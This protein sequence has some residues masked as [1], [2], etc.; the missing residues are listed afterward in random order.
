MSAEQQPIVE[1]KWWTVDAPYDILRRRE[2]V[3]Q[4]DTARLADV[5]TYISY[6]NEDMES[7]YVVKT[8]IYQRDGYVLPEDVQGSGT[9]VYLQHEDGSFEQIGVT[10]EG[11][12]FYGQRIELLDDEPILVQYRELDGELTRLGV[13]LSESARIISDEK[14]RDSSYVRKMFYRLRWLGR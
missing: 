14:C 4:G 8:L 5:D 12:A 9:R 11:G 3:E 2:L 13:S 7:G 10:V 6:I 1:Q